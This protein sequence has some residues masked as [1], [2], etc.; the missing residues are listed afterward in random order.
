M[1][2]SGAEQLQHRIQE[3][4]SMLVT[5]WEEMLS[6]AALEPLSPEVQSRVAGLALESASLVTQDVITDGAA[7]ELGTALFEL[8]APF[9]IEI[10]DLQ[11]ALLEYLADL[12][13]D[14]QQRDDYALGL[15]QTLNAMAL[16]FLTARADAATA[17]NIRSLRNLRHDLKTPIN[18]ITGFSK[19]ILNGIDGPITNFQQEDLTA[20]FEA[21]QQ[22]LSMLE[23]LT[24]V[25]IRDE[26]KATLTTT[27]FDVAVL[28]GDI[29]KTAQPLL[30]ER[31][32][33]F[34]VQVAGMLDE[35]TA[36]LSSLRWVILSSL[37]VL[38]RCAEGRNLRLE[39]SRS[40]QEGEDF[41]TCRMV[42]VGLASS[43]TV[44]KVEQATQL[45]PSVR[46]CREMGGQLV[47]DV[48]QDDL[49]ITVELPMVVQQD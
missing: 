9:A 5:H 12:L 26:R 34:T 29:M 11:A 31:E 8:T 4:I 49:V 47:I 22:L 7:R 35:M 23:D 48:Q 24:S 20:I 37:L 28:L 43:T 30:A 46:Y 15:H 38:G 19:V 33:T 6:L 3:T 21:G 39:V 2:E 41:L 13:S 45:V 18:A 10:V 25:V 42:G 36:P 14:E 27:T 17:F 40:A 1:C 44:Q 32:H 16:G